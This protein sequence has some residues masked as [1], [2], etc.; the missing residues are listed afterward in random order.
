MD[1]KQYI[2]KDVDPVTLQF[3][4]KEL[5]QLFNQLTYSHLPVMN[6]E[7][8]LG[9][10][11]ETDVHC[12]DA[13]KTLQDY[14]YALEPFSVSVHSNW[15]DVLEAFAKNTSNI[16]PVF[17][18]TGKYL[19]YFELADIMSLFHKT[20]FLRERGSVIIVQKE[21]RESSLSEI[22]QIAESNNAKILGVFVSDLVDGQL[23]TTIKVKTDN[24]NTVLQTYRRYEYD[25]V[26]S[27]GEDQL[28]E[29]LKERS[30]Y[31]NKY[32][33]I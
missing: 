3:S 23:Q 9:C 17:D 33:N 6:E 28:A 15:L 25:V 10:L 12:F 1:I 11:S 26:S 29:N 2:I 32:L 8:F 30:A 16:M 4:V 21:E 7:V 14:A 24:L 27:H 19:G 5:K 31:L 18:E 20:P 13:D 22:T